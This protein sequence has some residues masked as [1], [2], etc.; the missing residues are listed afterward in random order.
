MGAYELIETGS[1]F[2]NRESDIELD[3]QAEI[4]G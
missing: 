4:M 3:M 2:G 1:T